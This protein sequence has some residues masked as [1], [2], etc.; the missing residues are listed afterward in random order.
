MV[1]V[2]HGKTEAHPEFI[3]LHKKEVPLLVHKLINETNKEDK[4]A[5]CKAKAELI[6]I[7][8]HDKTKVRTFKLCKQCARTNKS[9]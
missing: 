5:K 9:F 4:C 3:Y 6:G 1:K 7:V 8:I 2:Y